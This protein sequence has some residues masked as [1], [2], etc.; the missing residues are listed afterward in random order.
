MRKFGLIG[1]PL[2]H[3]F[4]KKYFTEKFLKEGITDCMYENYPIDSID[5]LPSLINTEK[6]DGL[7]VTIPYKSLVIRFLDGIDS[8]AAV[9]GAVNVI[10]IK[11]EG[12]KHS[13]YGFNSDITGILDT[14]KPFSGIVPKSALVLGSGGSSRAVCHVL[15]KMG[16]IYSVVSRAPGEGCMSYGDLNRSLIQGTG[17]IINTT[18]LGMYPDVTSKPPLDYD[19]LTDRHVLFDLVYNPEIT[20][21]LGEGKKRGCTVLTGLTMLYS[22][23]ERSWQI[24]NDREL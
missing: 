5:R 19:L 15:K 11:K 10:R 18:P 14:L 16:F 9:I 17:I 21:F 8:E 7:N 6:P 22:Q 24:W 2:G 12:D 23:A 20:A 4:S 1:Y 13:L 3:S